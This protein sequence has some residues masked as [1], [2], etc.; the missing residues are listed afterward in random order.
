MISVFHNGYIVVFQGM[1]G[2]IRLY[3]VITQKTTIGTIYFTL[4][5]KERTI[6]ELVKKCPVF[7]YLKSASKPTNEPYLEPAESSSPLYSLFF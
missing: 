4:F 5:L 2:H 6:I 1:V 7:M 3:E